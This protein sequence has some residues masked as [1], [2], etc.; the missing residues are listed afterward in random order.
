M[1]DKDFA[2]A[3]LARQL[4]ADL[5]LL[6]TDV[7]AV[8]LNYGAPGARAIRRANPVTLSR[9]IFAAGSMG[10]KIAAATEFA[11]ET[12]HLAGIGQLADALAIARGERG[13]WIDIAVPPSSF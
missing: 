7:D 8:Y 4:H 3:L 5:L 13:T 2:S 12:G 6:L 11:I 9:E 1:I 10:P